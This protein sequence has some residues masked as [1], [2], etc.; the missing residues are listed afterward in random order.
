MTFPILNRRTHLYLGLFLTPWVLMYAVSSIPFSH[1]DYF[2][3]RDKAKGLPLWTKKF[4]GPYD[5]GPIPESGPLK[6]VGAKVVKDFGMEDS[7]Y[8][9]YR[10]S[11]QQLN[12]YVHTFWRSTQFKYFVEEK[13]LVAED[14]RFRFEHFLT[15]MHARGGYH[16]ARF[17]PILWAVVIDLVCLSFVIWILSGLYMWW[18]L[19]GVRAWGWVALAGGIGSFAVFLWRL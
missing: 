16:D 15:G 9:V 19:P 2:E 13:R 14:R 6:P 17:F 4:D 18:T 11:P 8:G 7:A 10:Q 5:L 12:I 3:E 1:N